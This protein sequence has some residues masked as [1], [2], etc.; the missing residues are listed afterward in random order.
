MARLDS[1]CG[2]PGLFPLFV[3]LNFSYLPFAEQ[4]LI[5]DLGILFKEESC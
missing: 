2:T 3:Y 1:L 4:N 5:P